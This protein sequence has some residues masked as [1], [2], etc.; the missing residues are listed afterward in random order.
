MDCFNDEQ[1]SRQDGVALRHDFAPGRVAAVFFRP[2]IAFL[3]IANDTLLR[4]EIGLVVALGLSV[5]RSLGLSVLI[6]LLRLHRGIIMWVGL[7]FFTG[8]TIAMV[9]RHPAGCI[10]SYAQAARRMG[11]RR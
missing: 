11:C 6:S 3:I 2:W 9:P 4:V 1:Q 7:A 8:A 10:A 5:S